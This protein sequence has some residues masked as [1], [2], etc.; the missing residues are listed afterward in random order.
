MIVKL[1]MNHLD[2]NSLLSDQQ[3]GF[4]SEHST[5]DQLLLTYHEITAQVDGDKVVDLL[6]FDYSKAFDRVCHHILLEKLCCLGVHPSLVA[7]IRTFLMQR[8]MHVR[9][10]NEVS[11]S[12]PVNSGVPQGSALGPTLFLIYVN[13]VVSELSCSVKLFA[14]DIKLYM[15]LN[16][17]ELESGVVE[18]QNNVDRLV[19]TGEAWG[20]SINASKCA[21]IRFSRRRQGASTTNVSP[22]NVNGTNI[23]FVPSYRDLGVLVDIDL[24]FHSHIMNRVR[25][26]NCLTN[27]ILSSTV[28]RE[29]EFIINIYTSHVRPILEY[30]S[31]VWN[32]GYLGDLRQLERVQ[33]RWTRVVR[34]LE[35][36]PYETRLKTLN[37]F[38]FQGRLLRADLILVYKIFHG[39]CAI[40]PSE[41]FKRPLDSRTRGHNYKLAVPLTHI[42]A[43]RRFFSVRVVALWNSLQ[44]DTVEAD[45]LGRFKH[46]LHRDLGNIL[47]QFP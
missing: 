38:S 32:T 12:V 35:E 6:F 19:R 23:S 42:E 20:L 41:L 14:D 7:W 25:F 24:K 1:L 34:G 40:N 2:S 44:C 9:I 4:R 11:R 13:H 22:Y 37:L 15:I 16:S 36:S 5:T 33:R 47:Y 28:C 29:A 39:L 3:F 30:G 43:R 31:S 27:N 45:T 18:A 26:V 10:G 17:T 8:T 21:C 46:L